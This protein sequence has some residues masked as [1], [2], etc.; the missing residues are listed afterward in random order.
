MVADYCPGNARGGNFQSYSDFKGVLNVIGIHLL[1]EWENCIQ[2]CCNVND[3]WLVGAE[4]N[5]LVIR[6]V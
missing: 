5:A 2:M 1:K 4:N 6:R 3:D